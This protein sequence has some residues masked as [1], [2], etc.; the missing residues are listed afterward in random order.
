MIIHNL[1]FKYYEASSMSIL[2]ALTYTFTPHKIHVLLGRS[3]CGKSTLA[4]VMS[5][6][7]EEA[8]CIQGEVYVENQNIFNM[9]TSQRVSYIS[10]MFQ[11]AD[12]QFCMSTLFEELIFCLENQAIP[13]VEILDKVQQVVEKLSLQELLHR[14]LHTLSGGEKQRCAL[15]CM[16]LLQTKVL[17]LDEP[18]AN[19]DPNCAEKLVQMIVQIQKE[20]ELTILVIDHILAR[21]IAV[22]DEIHLMKG[23]SVIEKTG[24]TKENI[25]LHHAYFKQH[26]IIDPLI[27]RESRPSLYNEEVV[28]SLQNFTLQKQG[29]YFLKDSNLQLRKKEVIAIVGASG[30]GKT[31][32]LR[33]LFAKEKV[34]GSTNVCGYALHKKHYKKLCQ[35]LGV[36]LQ[37]PANQFV[38][39]NVYEEVKMSVAYYE[40]MSEKEYENKIHTLLKQ[41]SLYPYLN[42]SP[43]MLSQGQQRRLAALCVLC[44][45]QEVLLLDEPTYGQD[46]VSC[47]VIMQQVI[48]RVQEDGVS[49]IMTTHDMDVALAYA[50]HVY[51]IQDKQFVE[52]RVDETVTIKM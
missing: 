26:G 14:K 3:G 31:T 41:F 50:D 13:Q 45:K 28:V 39:H 2:D 17:V 12:A 49:V 23:A 35:K 38:Q 4:S 37:N 10:M 42:Y 29:I 11:N 27:K 16:L 24:I 15:A 44:A 20:Y 43:Y 51:A 8:A 5:G 33:S 46:D 40:K 52:V 21:W 48:K 9:S 36:V 7:I 18:F 22:C 1:H 30:C 47:H 19:L 25:H 32:F 34:G 6:L